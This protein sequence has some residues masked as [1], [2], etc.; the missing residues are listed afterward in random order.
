MISPDHVIS[1]GPEALGHGR[2]E[3]AWSAVIGQPLVL[4]LYSV[5]SIAYSRCLV[6]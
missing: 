6:P 4:V 3:A 5:C 1:Y 2:G